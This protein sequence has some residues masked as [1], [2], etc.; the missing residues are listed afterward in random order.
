MAKKEDKKFIED[1]IHRPFN[2]LEVKS[3]EFLDLGI[4][5]NSGCQHNIEFISAP[6]LHWPDTIFSFDHGTQILYTCDAFG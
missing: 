4:N 2:R 5:K 1:Q 6:N 3:G